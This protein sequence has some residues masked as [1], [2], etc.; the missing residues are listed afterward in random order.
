MKPLISICIPAF[1]RVE[2][3]RRLLDS[4]A[5]Q[6]FNNF[7]VVVADDSPDHSV[8]V[9]LSEYK[10]RFSINYK[11]NLPALG[12]PANWNE[13]I[14]NSAGDWVKLMHDD[15]W[16][17]G[18]HSLQQFVDAA[19]SNPGATFI[20][21]GYSNIDLLTGRVSEVIISE[22]SLRLLK[23]SPLYLLKKNFIGPP[24]TTMLKRVVGLEYDEHL[25]W[26]VDIE[27]YMRY[28][29][30]D[31][32]IVAIREALVNIG[33]SEHQVTRESF[34]NPEVEIPELLYLERKLPSKSYKNIY[35]YDHYW[36]LIRNFSIRSEDDIRKYIPDEQ[37]I[38]KIVAGMIKFQSKWPANFLKNGYVSKTLMLSCYLKDRSLF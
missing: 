25:K 10:D 22:S 6:S 30:Q 26:V 33:L 17:A 19:Q 14:R 28:L 31:N 24:S 36:R 38:S 32:N 29:N 11:K 13:A 20:F 37:P 21:S 7:E 18:E 3:I 2:Y 8:E 16:F 27:F 23:R 12:S 1:K 4:I 9:L 15:D 35:V 34:R 5:I